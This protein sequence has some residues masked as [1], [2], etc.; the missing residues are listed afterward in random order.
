ML[1][2]YELVGRGRPLVLLP[3][4]FSDRRVWQRVVG[5]LQ[6]RYQCLL[7]DPRGTGQ[8]P[9][10]AAAFTVDDLAEDVLQL[11]DRVGWARADLV[12]HS[13]GAATAVTVAGRH[14]A[15]VRHLVAMGPAVGV[16]AYL[17]TVLDHWEALARSDLEDRALA[18]ALVLDAFGRDA[19]QRLV[20]AVLADW[21]RRPI[22]REAILRFVACDR[23]QDVATI[24]SRVDAP[25]LIV[26]GDEDALAGIVGGERLAALIPG[27]RLEIVKGSG[28][29]PQIERPAAVARLLSEFLGA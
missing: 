27:A 20:P 3:G 13:L 22:A 19:F 1:P 7:Y 29:T 28:H 14:P 10:P 18:R 23:A 6:R 2:A 12:G 24:A 9:D 4:T 26:A 21:V 11:M 25:T 17:A 8:T 5:T 15:R 16:D